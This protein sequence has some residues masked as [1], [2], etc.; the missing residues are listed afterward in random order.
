MYSMNLKILKKSKL[1]SFEDSLCESN[2]TSIGI[3]KKIIKLH[4]LIL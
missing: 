3:V 4:L 2:I 1:T